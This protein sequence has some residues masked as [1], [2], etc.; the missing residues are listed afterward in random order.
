MNPKFFTYK[1]SLVHKLKKILFAPFVTFAW[2][3][4]ANRMMM[5]NVSRKTSKHQN[6]VSFA[7]IHDDPQTSMSLKKCYQLNN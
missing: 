2:F 5:Q 3:S 4:E 7:G 6:D 1:G